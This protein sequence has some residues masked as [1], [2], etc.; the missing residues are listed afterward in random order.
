MGTKSKNK[1]GMKD[2]GTMDAKKARAG[3]PDAC[4]TKP[5]RARR[6]AKSPQNTRKFGKFKIKEKHAP[7]RRSPHLAARSRR[8]AGLRLRLRPRKGHNAP[9]RVGGEGQDLAGAGA[10]GAGAGGRGARLGFVLQASGVP[11]LAFF[12]SIVPFSFIPFIHLW[13]CSHAYRSPVPRSRKHAIL[14]PFVSSIFHPL[15]D[16]LRISS[17]YP[18]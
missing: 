11:A 17:L 12:A 2:N 4:K 10:R 16:I 5:K 18:P 15:H 9:I 7:L 13:P 14:S 3:T 6:L 1:N 8:R